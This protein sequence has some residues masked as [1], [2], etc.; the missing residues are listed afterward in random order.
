[1]TFLALQ[2]SIG[3]VRDGGARSQGA[4]PEGPG[5]KSSF[6][7]FAWQYQLAVLPAR[8]Q[9]G[10]SSLSHLDKGT[11][12]RQ[13]R[14]PDLRLEDWQSYGLP[15]AAARAR[16]SP[17]SS[18]REAGQVN[19]LDATGLRREDRRRISFHVTCNDML[20]IHKSPR[21]LRA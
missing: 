10:R 5:F 3:A 17:A 11:H 14:V 6:R 4:E 16:Q 21:N 7:K 19:H 8:T 18:W 2:Q 13:D 20:T 9:T 1:M 12:D 15:G